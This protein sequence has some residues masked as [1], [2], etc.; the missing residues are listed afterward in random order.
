MLYMKD[1]ICCVPHYA[2]LCPTKVISDIMIFLDKEEEHVRSYTFLIEDQQH[3]GEKGEKMKS[4]K[5]W[6]FS[7]GFKMNDTSMSVIGILA[8]C[9]KKAAI[10][11]VTAIARKILLITKV[12]KLFFPPDMAYLAFFFSGPG[13]CHPFRQHPRHPGNGPAAAQIGARRGDLPRDAADAPDAPDAT[14]GGQPEPTAETTIALGCPVPLGA[15][16]GTTGC[17]WVVA[18]MDGYGSYG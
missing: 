1:G 5:R 4:R 11:P 16:G 18:F 7:R 6:H 15:H 3:V 12:T 13:G 14:G 10:Q 17:D 9:F 8:N 2:P